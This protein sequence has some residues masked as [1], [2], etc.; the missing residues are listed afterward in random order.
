MN[1]RLA[2]TLII[3]C[4][5]CI[6]VFY[7]GN[8][9]FGSNVF[10]SEKSNHVLFISS[11]NENFESVP[12]QLKGIKS[13]LEPKQI[14][15]DAEYMDTKRFETLENELLFYQM[16]Q[17]KLTYLIPYDAIIVGDDAAL[18]FALK[19]QERLFPDVPIVFLGINNVQ[20]ANDANRNSHMTGIIEEMYLE[21]NINLAISFQPNAKKVV[22]IVDDTYT[23]I[24]DA[25]QF[26]QTAKYFPELKFEDIN[27]SQLN[28]EELKEVFA[29]IEADTIVLYLSMYEDKDGKLF[30]I[31]EA[32]RII[33]EY[34]KGPIYRA[35]VGGIGDGILGG[36]MV[37]YEEAGQLAGN[38]VLRY[39]E[40]ES[41]ESIEMVESSPSY[42][43]LDNE[44][45]LQYQID[46]DKL[47]EGTQLVNRELSFYEANKQLVHTI[48]I[49][50]VILIVFSIA[51]TID[52]LLRRKAEKNLKASKET[53]LQTYDELA[54]TEEELR[55]QFEVTQEHLNKI[56]I[57]NQTNEFLA[58][59]DYLTKLPNRMNFMNKLKQ[60]VE[61]D[62]KGAI[63]LLDLDNF[64]NVND[65][66]GH[67]YGDRILQE[68]A[69]RL[70]DVGDKNTYV[71][72]FGGDEFLILIIDVF[73]REEIIQYIRRI[74]AEFDTPFKLMN[75]ENYIQFS[76]G[77]S[78]FPEDCV[79]VNQLIMYADTA[80]YKAKNQGK[81]SFVFYHDD[82]LEE[83]R[84]KN[85]IEVILRQALKEDGFILHYQP[86]VNAKTGEIASFE[87][88]LRLKEHKI[89]PAKFISVAE[90]MG[91]IIE[92]GRWVT[93][94]VIR[95]LRSWREKNFQLKTIAINFSSKQL[96]DYNYLS[97]LEEELFRNDIE[98]K[99]IEIEITEGSLLHGTEYTLEF[100]NKLNKIGVKI[101]LDD[102]GTGFSSINYLTY[103]PAGKVKLDKSL[104][105]KFLEL[106][107]TEVMNS[108]I[109]LAHGL[110]MDITAEGIEEF[111]QYEKLTEGG[112]DYIQGYLFSKPLPEE[113]LELIYHDNLLEKQQQ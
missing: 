76:I 24:G 98:S 34:V 111:Y 99:Y 108:I 52:N 10:A 21:D 68:I 62:K 88:L 72:R 83:L 109:S 97:F 104:S 102:F 85:E 94:E 18:Q 73:Q 113:E 9:W 43:I 37:S 39:L 38:M 11:Y 81:N 90:D 60:L 55:A 63:L 95:Q 1:L 69:Q 56:E 79:E 14:T 64:K 41:I 57:L 33:S 30:T 19:Y 13:V 87:A 86:Q 80:M 91:L 110:N 105:D 12:L 26:Y 15:V 59:H 50:M 84:S 4:G 78:V 75:R 82:M 48:I 70:I 3:W 22:A 35:E 58:Q 107:N 92:I 31:P 74:Q 46:M 32:S 47:P 54:A 44:L 6:I 5:L 42:Y 27:T 8:S 66:L 106:D 40:G 61:E 36:K 51:L 53:L 112:C 17:Y 2:K 49:I 101:A 29:K 67:A 28:L 71:C 25:I 96:R 93:K 16:L 103:I 100:L 23:G 89:S 45:L 65:I 20:R 77:I 7:Y